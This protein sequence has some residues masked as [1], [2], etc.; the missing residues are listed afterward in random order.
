M[1]KLGLSG[2]KKWTFNFFVLLIILGLSFAISTTIGLGRGGFDSEEVLKQYSFY[3]NGYILLALLAGAFIVQFIINRGDNKYGNSLYFASQGEKPSVPFFKRFS[4]LQLTFL[5]IIIFGLLAMV[6]FLVRQQVYTG[7]AVLEQQ[8]TVVDSILFSTILIPASENLQVAFIAAVAIVLF[9]ILARRTNMTAGNFVIFSAV[10]VI[11]IFGFFGWANHLLRYG[12]S[13]IDILIV[14][15]FWTIGG[16]IT[17]VTGSFIPFWIMHMMNNL[18]FDLSRWFT[19]E[20]IFTIA[21]SGIIILALSYIFI[22]RGR[23]L[24]GKKKEDA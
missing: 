2:K 16:L 14:I 3:V 7:V 13:D 24:G 10:I 20:L 23:L 8:F 5:S 15:G 22:Y 4:Q 17:F 1:M 19:N 11:L 18:F 9:G 21:M 6:S 12:G